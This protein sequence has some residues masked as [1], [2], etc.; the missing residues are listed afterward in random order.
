[1]L[2]NATQSGLWKCGNPELI[3]DNGGLGVL[4][5][6]MVEIIGE[7]G[8]RNTSS[9]FST[10]VNGLF[11][12]TIQLIKEILLPMIDDIGNIEGVE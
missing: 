5:N 2:R 10:S 9:S 3:N 12:G 4:R 11:G 1:M 7:C 6:A 8:K